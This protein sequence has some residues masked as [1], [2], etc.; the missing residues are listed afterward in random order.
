MPI[1]APRLRQAPLGIASASPPRH[2]FE[3]ER[4]GSATERGYDSK[5]QRVR[6]GFI[7]S[8]PLC[9]CCL[10]NGVISATEVV[11]HVVPHRGDMQ[12]FWDRRNW[13]GL[14]WRC[15]REIKSAIEAMW[16]RGD[17]G[18][19]GLRLDRVLLDFFVT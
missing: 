4:R 9:V 8:H 12:L 6:P 15:H 16:D 1:A 14:C 19:D 2:R 11:D 10:A 5:W 3:A 7:R 17:I 18:A 13:Q